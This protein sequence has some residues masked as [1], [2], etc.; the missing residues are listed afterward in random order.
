MWNN[1]L[2]IKRINNIYIKLRNNNLDLVALFLLFLILTLIVFNPALNGD[3]L[4][5]WDDDYQITINEDVKTFNIYKFFTSFYLASYQPLASLS[6]AIEYYF[7]GANS[8][9]F[10]FTNFVLYAFNGV[11]LYRFINALT[12]NKIW[13]SFA[14]ACIYL[15]HPLQN[16]MVCWISTRSTLMTSAFALLSFLNYMKYIEFGAKKYLYIVYLLCILAFFTKSASML[17]PVMLFLLD[18]LLRRKFSLKLI[19]EKIPLFIGSFIIGYVSI[20]SR[21]FQ[22][23]K[24]TGQAYTSIERLQLITNSLWFY[25]KKAFVPHD[26]HYYYGYPS[27]YFYDELPLEFALS[28]IIVPLIIIGWSILLKKIPK[29]LKRMYFFGSAFFVMN[30]LPILNFG[31]F[32]NYF[33]SERYMYFP[34][35]GFMVFIASI[36]LWIS[37]Q[38]NKYKK[39]FYLLWLLVI[40]IFSW[41]NHQ[42]SYMWKDAVEFFKTNTPRS[43]SHYPYEQMFFISYNGE[44]YE[45]SVSYLDTIIKFRPDNLENYMKRASL[46][47]KLGNMAEALEDLNKLYGTKE[48]KDEAIFLAL[49]IYNDQKDQDHLIEFYKM[50]CKNETQTFSNTSKAI[51]F[52]NKVLSEGNLPLSNKLLIILDSQF[53]IDTNLLKIRNKRSQIVNSALIDSANINEISEV[54]A[55]IGKWFFQNQQLDSAVKYFNLSVLNNPKQTETKLS[56]AFTL[57]KQNKSSEAIK[58]FSEVLQ[59]A[60]SSLQGEILFYRGQVYQKTKQYAL[61]CSDYIRARSLGY[62][63][64]PEEVKECNCNFLP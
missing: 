64:N 8:T 32:G 10:H 28:L 2:L 27:K 62:D 35:I 44:N 23:S 6:Y 58:L 13:M 18:Y 47:N 40:I 60:N 11:L 1:I 38:I 49:G 41:Q 43:D 16:E 21:G 19:V 22:T 46:N 54:Q 7:F 33:V 36:W 61:A 14:L 52:Y 31:S 34:L 17:F 59:I 55:S 5:G 39:H 57:S 42:R 50:L 20:I 26:L 45:Q 29:D 4:F 12:S 48:Y 51:L 63:I 9:V 24:F 56:L 37:P 3:F 30:L 53:V 25:I 15:V